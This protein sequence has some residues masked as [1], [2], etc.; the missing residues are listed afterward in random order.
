MATKMPKLPMSPTD[1]EWDVYQRQLIQY[2]KEQLARQKAK[3]AALQRKNK[4]L[5]EQLDEASL[6]LQPGE[7]CEI[8]A[9]LRRDPR[10]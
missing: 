1:Y 8:R 2:Q 7:A 3:I 4:H 9:R 10:D 5:Q 6:A